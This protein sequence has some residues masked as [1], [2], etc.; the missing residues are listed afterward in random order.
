MKRFIAHIIIYL[1]LGILLV[2]LTVE[3]STAQIVI[4]ECDTM[5][6]SVVSRPSIDETHFVWAIYNSS[7]NP[8]DVLDPTTALDPALYFVDGQYAGRAVQVTGLGPGKYYVRIQVWDEITC[9]DN[10]EMYV[11][12][13]IEKVP[14]IVL[15]GDSTCIGEPVVVKIIFTG[16]GPYTIDYGYGDAI[17]GNV[18]NMNG[19]IVDG[20]EVTIPITDPLP[21][22]PS[23][24]W[25]IKVE[26]DCKAYE[27]PVD[28]RPSSGIIIYPKPI[29]S[30]IYLK[31]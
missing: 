18:V 27:Y 28:E 31:N 30:K 4:D 5:E 25:I 9:T 16:V 24:F 12:E 10:V 19:V 2:A 11:M 8:T 7:P 17:T 29:N 22:G 26:D 23:S 20:P 15:E 6:F 13:V 14:E 21:V 1:T 3:N